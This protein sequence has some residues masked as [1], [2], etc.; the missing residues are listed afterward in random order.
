MSDDRMSKILALVSEKARAEGLMVID[1]DTGEEVMRTTQAWL[2]RA[3]READ[4]QI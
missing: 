3:L 1:E 4:S 2:V